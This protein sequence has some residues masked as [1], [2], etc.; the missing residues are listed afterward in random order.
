LLRHLIGS[1]ED[2]YL[3]IKIINDGETAIKPHLNMDWSTLYGIVL[4]REK[5]YF[6]GGCR[7]QNIGTSHAYGCQFSY[8]I[9]KYSPVKNNLK[10]K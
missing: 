6:D 5:W 9:R 2:L 1:S 8:N 4:K 7:K 3:T 10:N